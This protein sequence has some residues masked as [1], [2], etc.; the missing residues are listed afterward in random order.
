M[1]HSDGESDS[2]SS[3]STHERRRKRRKH[4]KKRHRPDDEKERR[5]KKHKRR[6]R[7]DDDDDGDDES[8]SNSRSSVSSDSSEGERRRRR[9]KRRRKEKKRE[10]REKKRHRPH[11]SLP[12]SKEDTKEDSIQ[13]NSNQAAQISSP[14]KAVVAATEPSLQPSQ[15][16]GKK[17]PMTREEYEALRN[18]VQ[19]V[20]DEQTG[21]YRLV[22]GTG[23]I[24]ER[25]VSRQDHQA[26][27]RQATYGD[28]QSFARQVYR[29]AKK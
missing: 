8:G 16:K 4:K 29:Q 14:A 11:S 5:K 2:S 27:N 25:I 26:I 20:Y 18:T 1:G 10:R 7:D 9:R 22:R 28:G 13:A 12:S 21:R 6:H 3:S 23:E 15:N 17:A 24:I 19:E